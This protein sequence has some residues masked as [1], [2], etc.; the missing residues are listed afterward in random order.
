MCVPQGDLRELGEFPKK[1]HRE[2]ANFPKN[3]RGKFV[4]IEEGKKKKEVSGINSGREKG[5]S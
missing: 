4:K 5:L 1:E 3:P 2:G